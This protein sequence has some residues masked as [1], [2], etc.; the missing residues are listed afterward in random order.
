MVRDRSS[1]GA[2]LG[3]RWTLDVRSNFCPPLSL[4]HAHNAS[5]SLSR[6]EEIPISILRTRCRDKV[7]PLGISTPVNRASKMDHSALRE[8]IQGE[9]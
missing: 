5:R 7:I 2:Q 6:R 3:R 1:H 9:M 8:N 4:L